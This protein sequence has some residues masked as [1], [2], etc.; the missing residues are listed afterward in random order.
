M[1]SVNVAAKR[2]EWIK[3]KGGIDWFV[4]ESSEWAPNKIVDVHARIM[5]GDDAEERA[6]HVVKAVNSYDVMIAAL[7]VIASC[8]SH[9]V[10]D[11]ADVA[12]RALEKAK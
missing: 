9:A 8:E 10:G 7:T 5:G 4:G 11:V 3:E 12:R 6:D 2:R 1:D